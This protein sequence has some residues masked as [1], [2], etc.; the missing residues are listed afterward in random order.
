[1]ASLAASVVIGEV[2]DDMLADDGGAEATKMMFG[3]GLSNKK[4]N[5]KQCRLKRNRA[6]RNDYL[7]L[8]KMG[9]AL[10]KAFVKS[11]IKQGVKQA[12]RQVT[13]QVAKR[14]TKQVVKKL[15]IQGA[16]A[17][18]KAAVAAGVG[19]AADAGL[20]KMKGTGVRK[21]RRRSTSRTQRGGAI[22]R[23]PT[24]SPGIWTDIDLNNAAK[25]YTR[26]RRKN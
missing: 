15:A 16:K 24:R 14:V 4:I 25:M 7:A 6:G 19:V 20:K 17:G 23:H 9:G 12:T 3:T 1:M 10:G 8:F 21:R 26:Q 18:A 11:G 22:L 2:L 5:Q 13:R